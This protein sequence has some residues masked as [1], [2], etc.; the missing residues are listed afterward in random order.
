MKIRQIDLPGYVAA[1]PHPFALIDGANCAALPDILSEEKD[2]LCLYAHSTAIP[3]EASPWITPITSRNTVEILSILP[4]D[5][6]WGIIFHSDQSVHALRAH[7]RHFTMLTLPDQAA[8]SYF[9]FYDP[10]VLVDAMSGLADW[11]AYALARPLTSLAVPFSPLLNVSP[12]PLAKRA[13]F[14][15]MVIAL[16]LP[17][18]AEIPAGQRTQVLS[19]TEKRALDRLYAR[20]AKLKLMRELKRGHPGAADDQIRAAAEVAAEL[21]EKHDMTSVRE[22]RTIGDCCVTHGQRFPNAYP[23]VLRIL[24]S[25][26]SERWQKGVWLREWFEDS[27]GH[28]M[29]MQE[30]SI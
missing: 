15:E 22:L 8:P 27:M 2:A 14:R 28:D 23:D 29:A 17:E 7:F 5:T 24:N 9:R 3:E 19:R 12:D 13:E 1:Q 21:S 30:T 20:R 4:P 11:R 18:P 26:P 6:H 10:R 25:S 16:P